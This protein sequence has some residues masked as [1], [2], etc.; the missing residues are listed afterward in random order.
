[1]WCFIMLGSRGK[2]VI[3]TLV[4]WI[5]EWGEEEPGLSSFLSKYFLNN[6]NTSEE[7]LS[8]TKSSFRRTIVVRRSSCMRWISQRESEFG[9]KLEGSLKHLGWSR[10][11]A[12]G[13]REEFN[14]TASHR[15][16]WGLHPRSF[17]VRWGLFSFS[18]HSIITGRILHKAGGRRWW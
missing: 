18:F 9:E 10:D 14:E 16:I 2:H 3:K 11:A 12:V 7:N 1:M 17:R 4:R 15:K 6:S 13:P 5:K 8:C